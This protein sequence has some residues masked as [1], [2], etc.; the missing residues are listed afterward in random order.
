MAKGEVKYF[1]LQQGGNDTEHIFSGKQPRQA[2]LKAATRGFTDLNL[3][4]RGT[5]KIH[6]FKG[7]VETVD[8]PANRPS[9]LPAKVKKAKVKKLGIKRI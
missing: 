3:R 2:A 1:V 4:G 7:S 6:M 9:W 8:A 5:N